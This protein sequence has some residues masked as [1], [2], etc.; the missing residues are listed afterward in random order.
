M[1]RTYSASKEKN[2]AICGDKITDENHYCFCQ[3]F[4]LYVQRH[5]V[6]AD[7]QGAVANAVADNFDKLPEEV[8]A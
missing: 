4:P 1:G 3:N 8:L 5:M 7:G 2:R 6:T